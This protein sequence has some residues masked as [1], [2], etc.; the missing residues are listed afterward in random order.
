MYICVSIQPANIYL[1]YLR[2]EGTL[3]NQNTMNGIFT[4]DSFPAF[5]I[6]LVIIHITDHT[7]STVRCLSRTGLLSLDLYGRVRS[8][9][10]GVVC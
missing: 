2:N 3:F 7:H 1:P 8:V 10:T 4:T 9:L 5:I 6:G